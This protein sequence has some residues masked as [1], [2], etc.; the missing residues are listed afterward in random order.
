MAQSSK[1]RSPR[2]SLFPPEVTTV[3]KIEKNNERKPAINPNLIDK[4]S[5]LLNAFIMGSSSFREK[6]FDNPRAKIELKEV[7]QIFTQR[8]SLDKNSLQYTDSLTKN[9][10]DSYFSL[11][12]LNLGLIHENFLSDTSSVFIY[13]N[14]SFLYDK[15]ENEFYLLT[16]SCDN[17]NYKNVGVRLN[18]LIESLSKMH[19][20]NKF[21]NF[22]VILEMKI[23]G[24]KF[25]DYFEKFKTISYN[26]IIQSLQKNSI[27]SS[28]ER[29][30][31][32][33]NV[34]A[35]ESVKNAVAFLQIIKSEIIKAKSNNELYLFGPI[36]NESN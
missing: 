32:I 1:G 12:K 22:I 9:T 25:D 4:S 11:D 10:Y 18:E 14:T 17:N 16:S 19:R 8:F 7:N 21:K 23:I 34:P 15:N 24:D 28:T 35:N 6:E 27:N 26:L 5:S 31:D 33:I 30:A 20:D 2:G 13:I 36:S 29:I 3:I